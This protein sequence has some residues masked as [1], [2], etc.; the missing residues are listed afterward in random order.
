M[1][2][3]GQ[4]RAAA[5]TT[6]RAFDSESTAESSVGAVCAVLTRPAYAILERENPAMAKLVQIYIARRRFMA[7]GTVVGGMS[8]PKLLI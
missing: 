6:K 5:R 3:C 2:H 8:V 1:V 7:L 4:I